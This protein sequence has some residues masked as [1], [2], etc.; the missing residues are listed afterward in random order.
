MAI[1]KKGLKNKAKDTKDPEKITPEVKTPDTSLDSDVDKSRDKFKESEEVLDP[2]PEKIT[3]K[4][5]V[6]NGEEEIDPN[7][8]YLRQYQ[9]KKV[10]NK[11]VLGEVKTDPDKGSKAEIMKASLL[12]QKKISMLIPLPEG[13]DPTVLHS[14]SEEH[15]SELQSHSFIS[16][17]VFCLKKK[18]Y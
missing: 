1:T 10:D 17:A 9:Y 12:K 2:I 18:K 8:D 11:P 14:R 7:F 16:Y 5:E 6:D 3:S 4:E 13:T 15:T